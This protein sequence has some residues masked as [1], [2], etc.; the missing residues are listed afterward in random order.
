MPNLTPTNMYLY[1]VS[2]E[3]GSLGCLNRVAAF[4]VAK[5]SPL[6]ALTSLSLAEDLPLV[7]PVVKSLSAVRWHRE[8]RNLLCMSWSMT[9]AYG[10]G[11]PGG[12][13]S[14]T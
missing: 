2:G 7:R 3:A 9:I 1:A 13:C 5:P 12:V 14:K 4:P 6:E 8:A 11:L 10:H